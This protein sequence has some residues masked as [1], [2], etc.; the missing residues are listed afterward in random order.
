NI[1][2]DIRHIMLLA[3][4][5]TYSGSIKGVVRTGITKEKESPFARA[6]FEETVK[7]LLEAAFKG[8]EEKLQGVVENIIVGVPIK[9]GTGTVELVLEL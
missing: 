5:M 8:E 3:D 4:L 6:A 7:H 9:I 2:V 1:L